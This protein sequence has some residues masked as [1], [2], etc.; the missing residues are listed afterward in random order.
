MA[1]PQQ[2]R[3]QQLRVRFGQP[4]TQLAAD[5]EGATVALRVP[6]LAGPDTEVILETSGRIETP[7]VGSVL[8]TGDEWLAGAV[9]RPLRGPLDELTVSLYRELLLHARG[10]SIVRIW[11]YLPDINGETTGLENYRR[12][13]LGRWQAYH[14]AFGNGL[15]AHLPAA[16]A[17]GLADDK[18]TTLFLATRLPV[19]SVENPEQTPAWRYPQTYGPKAPSFVRGMVTSGP[20]PRRAWVSG[21]AS[22]RGHESVHPGDVPRQLE[23][24][25][26]NLELVLQSM[27]LPPLVKPG[28][29]RHLTKVYLRRKAELERVRAMLRAAGLPHHGDEATMYLEA[30]VCR[31]ELELEIEVASSE[32]TA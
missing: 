19:R 32:R 17:V 12:F 14:D 15:A 27:A 29:M 28:S 1:R 13:N 11:N 10:W 23:V 18:L 24:T 26:Q 22:I 2:P 9:V 7:A 16:S 8:L 30:P 31:L 25:L 3:E 6:H 5:E 4:E 21:T 20:G